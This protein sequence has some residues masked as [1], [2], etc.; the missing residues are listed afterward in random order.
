M[1]LV[2]TIF[3]DVRAITG[4]AARGARTQFYVLTTLST[5]LQ[6]AAIL[7]AVPLLEALFGD[8]PSQAWTWV[9]AMVVTLAAGWVSDIVAT[10][11]GVRVGFG[12]IEASE[13]AGVAAIRH[14][15][16]ADLHG[17]RASRLRGLVTKSGPDSVSAVPLLFSPLIHAA[18]LIP[19]LAIGLLFVSWQ[20]AAVALVGGVALLVA[21]YAGRAAVA[22]AE[23]AFAESGRALDDRM[24]EFGWAQPTLRAA[25]VGTG[26]VDHV[27]ADSRS[28]GF[29]L[30]AWQVPGDLLFTV[31]GQLVL[32]AFGVTT[33]AL[34]LNDDLSGITAAAMIV[35]LLR[36][37]ETT[38]SLSLL[39]TP[40]AGVERLL[41]ELR[42]L[43]DEDEKRPADIAPGV[44]DPSGVR[45]PA[46]RLTELDYRYPDGTQAL[47]GVDLDI[48]PGEITVLV[49]A[50]GSG[51]STLLDVLA[52]LREPTMG[53]VVVD[54]AP[55]SAQERLSRG[56]VV[57][58]TTSLRP[59]TLRENVVTTAEPDLLEVADLARLDTVLEALPNGWD[60]R[61]GDGA[62]ALSG[63]ERQRVGLARALAKPAGLLLV[64]EA[65]SSLDVITER[66]VADSLRRIRG[67]RTV[68]A[69]THRPALVALADSVIVLDG[70][71]VV[72]SGAVDDLLARGGV[73][74]DLWQRW[75]ESEGWQV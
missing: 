20:L 37:V 17:D 44:V 18:L 42:G 15:D 66:A 7:L 62:N 2:P 30:L 21:F 9:G 12:L 31:V 4:D 51:K 11:A 29:R 75:R 45:P 23:D 67:T 19:M 57:F 46:V 5:A 24:L 28:R 26:T 13:C 10:R 39:A 52:G 14:L 68:V 8:T 58:Q 71:R 53:D 40:I 50:S 3:S 36:V 73:F 72:D 59:G 27:V 70:G 33:G 54:G 49:G 48:A 56:S 65:T 43:V 69:V 47:N 74:A 32:L 16:T 61:V 60:S 55:L 35:V 38:G 64:D 25:G 1:T 63:G 34:Y 22:K 41:D 6:A